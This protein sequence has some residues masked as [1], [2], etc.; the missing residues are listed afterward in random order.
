MI[1][2]PTKEYS[3]PSGSFTVPAGQSVDRGGVRFSCGAGNTACVVTADAEAGEVRV[4]GDRPPTERLKFTMGPVP[5]M[6]TEMPNWPIEDAS[7]AR[8]LM[9]GST[10]SWSSDDIRGR[11]KALYDRNEV[12]S[13]GPDSP[14]RLGAG[15]SGD[16]QW[17]EI[18]CSLTRLCSGDYEYQSVMTYRDVPIVQVRHR[19]SERAPNVEI[20]LGG[21]LDNGFFMA[22][23]NREDDEDSE[24]SQG[25]Y[26][27]DEDGSG[28]RE[29]LRILTD[30]SGGREL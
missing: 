3:G 4:T 22:E 13:G 25:L 2:F 30:Y 11:I 27:I 8:S 10:L 6:L 16:V 24:G 20:G 28:G 17:G 18:T 29:E 19:L 14:L 15:F 23:L 12:L 26:Y 7:A 5:P 9:G 1:L 21:I